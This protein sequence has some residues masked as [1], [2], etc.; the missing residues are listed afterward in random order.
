MPAKT[1]RPIANIEKSLIANLSQDE[2]RT[3]R[4]VITAAIILRFVIAA[5]APP[6]SPRRSTQSEIPVCP[7]KDA[8]VK[9]AT[10]AMGTTCV[11]IATNEAPSTPAPSVQGFICLAFTALKISPNATRFCLLDKE[12]S[13]T[14]KSPVV[15]ETIAASS[16]SPISWESAP[17]TRDCAAIRTPE[18]AER[19]SSPATFSPFL[20]KL[21]LKSI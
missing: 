14:N 15:K 5:L 21:S 11:C 19:S 1:A 7:A 4:T 18:K 12:I 6:V 2:T 20:I 17:L 13:V 9:S 16:E 10:P 8:T 3:A